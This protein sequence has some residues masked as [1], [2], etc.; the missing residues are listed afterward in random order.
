[1]KYT[2]P[3]GST[4]AYSSRGMQIA[5]VFTDGFSHIMP[6]GTAASLPKTLWVAGLGIKGSEGGT[7]VQRGCAGSSH[8]TAPCCSHTSKITLPH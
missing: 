6:R 3:T 7:E 8:P 2:V 1:M 4:S 5:I